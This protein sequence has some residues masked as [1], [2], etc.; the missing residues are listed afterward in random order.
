MNGKFLLT[1]GTIYFALWLTAIAQVPDSADLS[2]NYP[3]PDGIYQVGTKFITLT[4]LNR[5]DIYTEEPDDFRQISLRFWYPSEPKS[6]SE[7]LSY[8]RKA[9]A[10]KFLEMGLFYDN[11]L[12]DI[13]LRASFSFPEAPVFKTGDP[14]PL[15]IYSSTGVMNANIFLF[16]YLASHGYIVVSVGHP[17]WCLFYY[18]EQGN[19]YFPDYGDDPYYQKMWEEERSEAVELLKEQ[20]TVSKNIDEKRELLEELNK[21]M[22]V[23]I[24]DVKLWVQDFD[25]LTEELARLNEEGN[26]FRGMLDLEKVGIMGYSKGGVAAAHACLTENR[27]KAG[28]NLSGFMFGDIHTRPI[29]VPF[30]NIESEESWCEDCP[31]INDVLF[32]NA[33]SDIFM[34]QIKGATHGNFTDLSAYKNYITSDFDGLLGPIDGLRF[35]E[36]QYEYTLNFLDQ[37]L[38][39]IPSFNPEKLQDK[40]DEVRFKT[41]M[42]I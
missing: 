13:A 8:Y 14:F 31:P 26:F 29:K 22:P 12:P 16:E 33:E 39:G 27:C 25:F 36:I 41:N 1:S 3:I 6:G 21:G 7:P 11:F 5:P 34:V 35:L 28:I 2:F 10:D 37:Y 18:D 40:Y 30:L 38:K 42:G 24:N 19:P 32:H 20:I 9:V 17:H 4:D 15:V 23:E